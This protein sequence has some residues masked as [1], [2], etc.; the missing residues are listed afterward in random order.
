MKHEIIYYDKKLENYYDEDRRMESIIKLQ[1]NENA[2]GTKT[3][4]L[5]KKNAKKNVSNKYFP[6]AHAMH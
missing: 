5:P 1:T 2:G 6:S 4:S 3:R